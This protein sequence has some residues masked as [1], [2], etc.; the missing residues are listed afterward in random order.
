MASSTSD[1]DTVSTTLGPALAVAIVNDQLLK[2][3]GRWRVV[4]QLDGED[5]AMPKDVWP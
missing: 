4:V 1:L 5:R 2:G 3:P